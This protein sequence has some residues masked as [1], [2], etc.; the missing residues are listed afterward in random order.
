[1]LSR[2]SSATLYSRFSRFIGT[3]R[4]G[5]GVSSSS[6][7]AGTSSLYASKAS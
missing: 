3:S 1:M 7:S 6:S 2:A 5:R 4:V